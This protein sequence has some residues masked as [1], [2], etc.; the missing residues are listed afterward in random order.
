MRAL[1]AVDLLDIWERGAMQ[2]PAQRALSLLISACPEVRPEA[3][4][5]LSIG[6]RD[7]RLL[8]LREWTFGPQLVCSAI[9]PGC[10][11]RLEATF[12][13]DDIRVPTAVVEPA[14]TFSL[15]VA[16]YEFRCRLPNGQD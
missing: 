10:G 14:E 15:S 1:S 16:D 13:I 4:A 6:Q 11:E 2:A 3:L 8:T 5:Q 7:A 12:N 9:C